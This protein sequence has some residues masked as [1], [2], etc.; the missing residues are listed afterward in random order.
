[1]EVEYLTLGDLEPFSRNP[2]K[3][4]ESQLERIKASMQEFG[5]TNPILTSEDNMIVAG[6]GRYEAAKQLGFE[7]VPVINI[8]LPYEKAVAYVIADNRLAEI[9]EQDDE[10]LASLLQEIDSGLY[11]AIGFSEDE[12]DELLSGIEAGMQEDIV[13]DEPPEAD[14]ENEPITH[15]GDIWQLGNHR[16]MCGD[17]TDTADVSNLMDGALCNLVITDPP[18]NVSYVGKTAD[19]L[20]IENDEM[21]NED[22]YKFL[23]KVYSN[24]YEFSNDG[25]GIYVF[26]ADTEG[27]NFRKAMIDSGYKLAQCCIWVKNSMVMGRQDY[28]W[29]HEPVLVGWKPTAGHNWYSDRKQTTVWEFNRP[30]SSQD[31]PTMKP[32]EL[33]AYPLQN[34]SRKGDF[35]L[36]LF[37]GSGSTMMACEQ[38]GRT[39]YSMELN[40]KYCDVIIQRYV[41][42]TGDNEII[43]NGDKYTWEGE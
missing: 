2:K 37:G 14:E 36:D 27:I 10:Q 7:K 6:H 35:V 22:F 18:Y 40:P 20:T 16:L 21:S 15:I 32:I 12:I 43:R 30:T 5:W 3:H 11:T 41:N 8:G 13:E 25:A 17:S 19:G 29:Q 28:H 39:N 42:F 34:S 24:L 31:H 4:P 9:A 33:V 1:M 38:T 26:H 23:L